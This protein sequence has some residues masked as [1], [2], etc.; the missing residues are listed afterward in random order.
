MRY[1][2][3]LFFTALGFF[4]RL[5]VPAWVPWSPQRLTDAG[6]YLP[7]VGWVVGA[8]A[9]LS[10]LGFAL[11]LPPSLAVLLSMALTV[12]ITGA[13]HED[14]FADS[15]DGL[16]GGWDKEQVLAIMKD[17]RIGSYGT[18]GMVL[19][20]LAKAAALMELAAPSAVAPLAGLAASVPPAD[21]LPPGVG[22]A[23][24]LLVAHPLSRLA[25]TVVMHRLPYVRADD[26]AK[27]AAVARPLAPAELALAATCGLLPL[28]LLPP[29]GAFCALL[30]AM[31]ATTWTARLFLRRLGGYTGDLLGATQQASELSIY[32]GLLV[33]APL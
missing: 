19:M 2:L 14:G 12:R 17:S 13:F 20:L 4:T 1:Q 5:P 26:S 18:I 11:I 31:V 24:A 30:A 22:V 7:L 28:L 21:P 25:A 10:V 27:S 9:A 15:C 29:A 32:L 23:L 8:I 6:R 16:G 33:V 3:E